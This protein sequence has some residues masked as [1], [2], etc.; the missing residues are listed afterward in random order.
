MHQGHADCDAMTQNMSTP[1]LW[2]SPNQP[3]SPSHTEDAK[4][5]NTINTINTIFN[6]QRPIPPP[7]VNRR[8]NR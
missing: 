2:R 3:V 6:P 5:L 8:N 1:A 7:R 4:R